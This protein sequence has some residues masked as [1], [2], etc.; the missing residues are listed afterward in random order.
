MSNQNL[1]ND[2]VQ[3][4]RIEKCMGIWLHGNRMPLPEQNQMK[5]S[6]NTTFAYYKIFDNLEPFIAYINPLYLATKII[7]IISDYPEPQTVINLCETKQEIF[8]VIY[9]LTEI[10][11]ENYFTTKYITDL[12][13]QLS[14]TITTSDI[15]DL[16]DD[17]YQPLLI[18]N[19]S[20]DSYMQRTPIHILDQGFD[21]FLRYV[22]MLGIICQI[23]STKE[24]RFDM[25]HVWRRLYLEDNH[26]HEQLSRVE[27]LIEKYD[28]KD[29]VTYYTNPSLS[30]SRVI[31]RAFH[32][33]S[34]E[35]IYKFR[36]F[37]HD[38][39]KQLENLRASEQ[40]ASRSFTK[41]YRG[42]MFTYCRLQ[43]LIDNVNGSI[44]CN[45]FL[46][47]TTDSNV[48]DI[49]GGKGGKKD[50]YIS[51]QLVITLNSNIA[52]PFAN[53]S[54]LSTIQSEQEILFAPGIIWRIDSWECTDELHTFHLSPLAD[55][56][57][58]R[59][60]L[61]RMY[62]INEIP[63]LALADSLRRIGDDKQAEYFYEKLL[64]DKSLTNDIRT[65][66]LYEIAII[67]K[68]RGNYFGALRYFDDIAKLFESNTFVSDQN[69]SMQPIYTDE[70]KNI[71][72]AVHNNRGILK[73]K[74]NDYQ[75]AIECFKQA[76]LMN[77]SPVDKALV[78]NNLGVLYYEKGRYKLSYDYHSKAAKLIGETH[79]FWP[80]FKRNFDRTERRY[81]NQR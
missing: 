60:E 70:N 78:Y 80:E 13:K 35:Y 45:G 53:I 76:L 68:E 1:S 31:N 17:T 74:Y 72:I 14:Q 15:D 12:F 73:A 54:E 44:V 5:L 21:K 66:V 46:S 48:A 81:R 27:D 77:G 49:F 71:S 26:N 39:Y 57:S 59:P 10:K 79:S 38:L 65:K 32:T 63:L 56:K 75:K 64:A 29:A 7:L 18:R 9:I 47:T 37:I 11:I 51:V 24:D 62:K 34:M 20:E 58:L 22:T 25:W 16:V 67:Q 23:T 33:E 36:S 42:K 6:L 28:E 50:G 2:K 52:C 40:S 61:I 30:L 4:K 69:S 43:E 55:H 19:I 3:I 8:E 41:L